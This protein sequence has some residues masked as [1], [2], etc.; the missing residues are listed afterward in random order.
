M[1]Q[2]SRISILIVGIALL[3]M[4]FSLVPGR[5]T[6]ADDNRSEW[7]DG[8]TTHLGVPPGRFVVLDCIA[9]TTGVCTQYNQIARNGTVSIYTGTPKGFDLLITDV[10]W[11]SF[12]NTPGEIEGVT[13]EQPGGGL[14]LF[15]DD[16]TSAANGDASGHIHFTAGII[17]SATPYIIVNT[18]QPQLQVIGYNVPN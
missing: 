13:L 6:R 10:S 4:V 8:N 7:H 12:G 3:T 16:Q 15:A 1:K 18:N 2:F 11:Q 14:H 17:Y 9:F 5:P